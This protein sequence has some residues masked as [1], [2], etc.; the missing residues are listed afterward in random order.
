MGGASLK[1]RTVSTMAFKLVL[2]FLFPLLFAVKHSQGM[3]F[4]S[5]NFCSMTLV[6][7]LQGVAPFFVFSV[8]NDS[9]AWPDP[10]RAA[11]NE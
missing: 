7:G 6:Y 2:P 3:R 4:C 1:L 9:L 5:N 10:S 8:A 11:E